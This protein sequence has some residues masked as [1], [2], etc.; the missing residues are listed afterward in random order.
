MIDYAINMILIIAIFLVKCFVSESRTLLEQLIILLKRCNNFLV[1]L[2]LLQ[3]SSPALSIVIVFCE[4]YVITP[5]AHPPSFLESSAVRPQ[6]YSPPPY[7]LVPVL[8]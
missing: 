1:L 3:V 6:P 7:R 2:H 4:F 8:D 5:H